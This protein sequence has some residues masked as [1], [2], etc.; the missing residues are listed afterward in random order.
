MPAPFVTPAQLEAIPA[1]ERY[2]GMP[3]LVQVNAN[4]AAWFQF[5]AASTDTAVAGL[6]YAPA[7]G[8]GRYHVIDR[9]GAAAMALA[10]GATITP[11]GRVTSNFTLALSNTVGAT[12]QIAN[13]TNM[14]DCQ[15]ITIRLTQ[16]G[17]PPSGGCKIT[18]GSKWVIDST[19]INPA[20]NSVSILQGI[21]YADIDKVLAD[22]VRVGL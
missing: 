16:P 5:V 15:A 3:M 7:A 1:T 11:N 18:L 12:R 9:N 10:D 13:P 20:A 8:S 19:D 22:I 14:R 21:Y 6:V 4:T 17:T 2:D